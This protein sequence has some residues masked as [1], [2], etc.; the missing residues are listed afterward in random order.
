M[1]IFVIAVLVFAAVGCTTKTRYR[2]K[3]T[4][5]RT[6]TIGEA[7]PCYFDGEYMEMHCFPPTKDALAAPKYHYLVDADFNAPVHFDA[8][9]WA[10][11]SYPYNITC[12]L[13]SFEHATCNYQE[14]KHGG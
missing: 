9:H 6:W 11:G 14:V 12:R 10:G 13:D 5:D 1:K 7:K 2:V 4:S 8:Q 3:M